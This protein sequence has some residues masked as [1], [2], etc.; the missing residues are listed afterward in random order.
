MTECGRHYRPPWF[1]SSPANAPH[2]RDDGKRNDYEKGTDIRE[3]IAVWRLPHLPP[4]Q[5]MRADLQRRLDGMSRASQDVACL[6]KFVVN[7][8][9]FYRGRMGESCQTLRVV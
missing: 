2:K 1:T 4:T 3:M 8:Y 5:R 7:R 6:R 9:W